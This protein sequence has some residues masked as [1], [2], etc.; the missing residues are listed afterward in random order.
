MSNLRP[1]SKMKETGPVDSL[2]IPLARPILYIAL[3]QF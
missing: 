3:S 2:E 1:I